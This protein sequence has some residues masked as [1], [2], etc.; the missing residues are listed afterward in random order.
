MRGNLSFNGGSFVLV[1]LLLVSTISVLGDTLYEEGFYDFAT[2]PGGIDDPTDNPN[3]P[4]STNTARATDGVTST[5]AF[6]TS[7]PRFPYYSGSEGNTTDR[8]LHFQRY[9]ESAAEQG[10]AL[11]GAGDEEKEAARLII[12]SKPNYRD[13]PA[14]NTT[15]TVHAAIRWNPSD[16]AIQEGEY[17]NITVYGSQSGY[18]DQFWNDGGIRVNAEGYE[19][20]FDAT[21]NCYVALGRCRNYLKKRKRVETANWMTLSCAIGSFVRPLTS[22]QDGEEQ[23]YK[24]M[25]LD[26]AELAYTSFAVG[27]TIEFRAVYSGSLICFANDAYNL[28]WNNYGSL[29]VTVRRVS[30]PPSNTTVYEPMLLPACDSAQVV[31]ANYGTA[32]TKKVQC[33]PNGGGSGWTMEDILKTS[34]EYGSGAP[35]Y[36]FDDLPPGALS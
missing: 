8:Y 18:S 36:I 2:Q 32:S 33:N 30:W 7:S 9:R 22:I 35:S 27:R 34:G 10:I 31:Y 20:Y 1:L 14:P 19:S 12:T 11:I 26:E 29:Q 17:Y 4:F 28:Y 15:F 3:T 23:N 21:S 16:F 24:W 6:T 13:L 5:S 25:P